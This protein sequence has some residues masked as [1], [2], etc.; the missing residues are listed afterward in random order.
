MNNEKEIER[1][2]KIRTA[3]Q[4]IPPE[5]MNK[6]FLREV[7]DSHI[8]YLY[9]VINDLKKK[10]NKDDFVEFII[11]DEDNELKTPSPGVRG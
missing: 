1:L 9:H 6:M 7:L 4:T 11:P 8:M 3:L 10:Q 2:T 5:H